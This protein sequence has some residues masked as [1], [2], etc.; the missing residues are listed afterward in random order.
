MV[1]VTGSP[2]KLVFYPEEREVRVVFAPVDWARGVLMTRIYEVHEV[3]TECRTLKVTSVKKAAK[4]G[5]GSKYPGYTVVVFE[6]DV[7]GEFFSFDFPS[8][9]LVAVSANQGEQVYRFNDGPDGR[10]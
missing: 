7:D 1:L 4:G 6:T 10:I 9:S 5:S 3:R 8:F 2:V